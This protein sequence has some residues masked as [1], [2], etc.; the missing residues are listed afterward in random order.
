MRSLASPQIALACAGF[1]MGA[2]ALGRGLPDAIPPALTLPGG[3]T[4]SI[5]HPLLAFL[6]PAWIPIT[7]A[8]LRALCVRDAIDDPDSTNLAATRDAIMLRIAALV[9]GVHA[10]VLA[11]VLGWLS[12]RPWAARIVPI[13]LGLTI[14]AVGNLLPKTRRNLAVG[15]R[16]RATL[17]DR[18]LWIR[19]HRSAGHLLVYVG[20]VI[21]LSAIA[22]PSPLGPG[23]ILL[24]GPAALVGICLVVRQSRKD[25]HA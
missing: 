20:G 15:I 6:L 23:M 18:A 11:A 9:T 21:V 13:M 7:D 2:F 8:L 22:L 10:I 25:L 24:A 1:A 14:I 3:E 4:V 17:A 5:G 19:T 12:G 16:T